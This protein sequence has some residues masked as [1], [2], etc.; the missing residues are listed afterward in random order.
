MVSRVADMFAVLADTFVIGTYIDIH[1][2]IRAE[3]EK[4]MQRTNETLE[5]LKMLILRNSQ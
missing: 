1:R 5:E 2:V 3:V 4:T